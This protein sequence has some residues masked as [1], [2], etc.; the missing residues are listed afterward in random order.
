MD[1]TA[2]RL[3][4]IG[5]AEVAII[6]VEGSSFHTHP[7]RTLIP[8]RAHVCVFTGR[9]VIHIQASSLRVAEIIRTYVSIITLKRR[10]CHALHINAPLFPTAHI[11]IGT[12]TICITLT[13][14]H[15]QHTEE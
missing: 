14:C 4:G 3:T 9:G 5:G 13:A 15:G 1:T 12:V 10:P 11:V 7:V 6:A 8:L 2:F